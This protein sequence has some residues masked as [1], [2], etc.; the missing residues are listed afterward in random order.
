[1]N[2]MFDLG[3]TTSTSE[4]YEKILLSLILSLE[5]I[6]TVKN[7][8]EQRTWNGQGKDSFSAKLSAW[9][10]KMQVLVQ[11]INT[12]KTGIDNYAGNVADQNRRLC[13]CFVNN[14]H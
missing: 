13:E 2:V 8:I 1:M 3:I 12:T 6:G 4:N 5:N 7:M 11:D 10:E 14:F 9:M